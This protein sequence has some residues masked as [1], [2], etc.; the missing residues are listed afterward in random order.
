MTGAV[1]SLPG[2]AISRETVTLGA[3]TRGLHGRDAPCPARVPSGGI[4]ARGSDSTGHRR[5][6]IAAAVLVRGI[7]AGRREDGAK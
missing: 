1:R 2:E 5:P 4:A 6:S 7:G 3:T